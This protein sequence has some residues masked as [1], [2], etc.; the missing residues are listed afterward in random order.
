MHLAGDRASSAYD[1]RGLFK[2]RPGQLWVEWGSEDT[3][4]YAGWLQVAHQGDSATS[5]VTIHLSFFDKLDKL[6]HG[7][8]AAAVEAELAEAL[9]RLAGSFA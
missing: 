2:A 5:E 9:D 4:A 6:Y 3:G 7:G 1:S 8:R